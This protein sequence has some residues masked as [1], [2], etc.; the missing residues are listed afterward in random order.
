MPMHCSVANTCNLM[1]DDINIAPLQ[2]IVLG[3]APMHISETWPGTLA[4]AA[5]ISADVSQL[6]EP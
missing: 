5:K 1:H 3:K 4:N 6:E 2:C